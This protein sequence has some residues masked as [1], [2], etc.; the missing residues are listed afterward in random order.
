MREKGQTRKETNEREGGRE[1]RRRCRNRAK[2][3]PRRGRG[4]EWDK[5]RE[6]KQGRNRKME[7]RK[8]GPGKENREN[9]ASSGK[10]IRA[11]GAGGSRADGPD[12]ACLTRNKEAGEASTDGRREPRRLLLVMPR[13]HG[14]EAEI[15]RAA[16]ALGY[17]TDFVDDRPSQSVPEKAL[18]RLCPKLLAPRVAGYC[19]RVIRRICGKTYDKV[20]LISGQSLCFDGRMLDRI[21]FLNPKADFVLYQ[22]DSLANFPKIRGLY[23]WFDRIF[24]FDPGDADRCLGVLYLPLFCIPEFLALGREPVDGAKE[25]PGGFGEKDDSPLDLAYL[26][27]A[28]PGRYERVEALADA[29]LPVCPRQARWHYLPSRLLYWYRRVVTGCFRGTKPS[30]FRYKK[31]SKQERLDLFRRSRVILDSPQDH[32]MGLTMRCLEAVFSGRKLITTNPAIRSCDF[33]RPENILVLES[34]EAG[35]EKKLAE[36]AL[37]F[38]QTPMVPLPESLCAR[39]SLSHWL[40]VVLGET[41]AAKE[42]MPERSAPDPNT[43][44]GRGSA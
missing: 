42:P 22:W 29:L 41:E 33:Y 26:G 13:F 20:L 11:P 28:H 38:V 9:A 5:E 17:E 12:R 31:C 36:Q 39:Y 35:N 34:G 6:M 1:Q 25:D 8:R 10:P 23:P 44:A 40:A 19:E 21:R 18:L 15:Q 43:H 16:E 30:D 14:Y 37:R 2:G 24:T 7:K 3:G 27:T 4:Q 32:Q